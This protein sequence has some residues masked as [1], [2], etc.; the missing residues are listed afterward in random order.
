MLLTL[1]DKRNDGKTVKIF[2]KEVSFNP[3]GVQIMLCDVKDYE[4]LQ[5]AGY[6]PAENPDR[7]LMLSTTLSRF[8]DAI[9]VIQNS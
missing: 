8:I 4:L 9:N 1:N 7:Q 6:Q 5:D 2:A 3:D